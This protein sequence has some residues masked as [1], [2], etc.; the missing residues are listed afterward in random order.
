MTVASHAALIDEVI[1]LRAG[2]VAVRNALRRWPERLFDDGSE[3][4][5]PRELLKLVEDA[6]GGVTRP[7]GGKEGPQ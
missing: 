2:L 3:C 4:W 7:P 6:L 1:R 5:A